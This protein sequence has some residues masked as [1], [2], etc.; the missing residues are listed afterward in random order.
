MAHDLGTFASLESAE[1]GLATL[2][3]TFT[4]G[5]FVVRRGAW[6]YTLYYVV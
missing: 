4:G 3:A 1:A 5:L 2:R 6:T